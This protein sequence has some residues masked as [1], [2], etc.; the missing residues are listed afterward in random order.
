MNIGQ[1]AKL[2]GITAKMIRYYEQIGLIS[3]AIRTD[4]GYRHYTTDDVACFRFI[5]HARALGFSTEQI[6]TLLLLWNNGERASADVKRIAIS[7]IEQLNNKITELQRMAN[8][9]EHLAKNCQGNDNPDCS[10]ISG[11]IEPQE[12]NEKNIPKHTLSHL[13]SA[14]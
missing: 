6:S 1:A 10:I 3:K 7:H 5:R 14:F 2:S 13:R 8:T 11:L 4:S 12:S 9:L